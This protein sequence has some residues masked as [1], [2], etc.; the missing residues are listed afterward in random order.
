MLNEDRIAANLANYTTV[1]QNVV[2]SAGGDTSIK[3]TMQPAPYLPNS[4]NA[5]YLFLVNRGTRK[6]PL[7]IRHRNLALPGG[8]IT[9]EN[10]GGE[11]GSTVRLYVPEVNCDS[12]RNT[13][14]WDITLYA[15]STG[16]PGDQHGTGKMTMV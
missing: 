16:F 3:V 6:A 8:A 4:D 13:E 5:I 1:S 14:T 7:Q 12:F 2:K 9:R 10:A 11:G 15:N